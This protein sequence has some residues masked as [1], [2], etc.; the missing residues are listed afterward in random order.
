MKRITGRYPVLVKDSRTYDRVIESTD[1]SIGSDWT[2][3]DAATT[4][5]RYRRASRR[6]DTARSVKLSLNL[7][8]PPRNELH[9]PRITSAALI[10]TSAM[11]IIAR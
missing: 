8:I 11:E 7:L 5:A 10:I 4:N 6:C 2:Q 3:A 9:T 1:F